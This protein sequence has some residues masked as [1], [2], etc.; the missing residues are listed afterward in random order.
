[1]T[2]MRGIFATC[3]ARAASGHAAAAPP[4]S[5]MNSRRFIIALTPNPSIH[6]LTIAGQAV[7][8]SKTGPLMSALGQKQRSLLGRGGG[9]CPLLLQYRTCPCGAVE[10]R[11]VPKPDICS[12]AN[13][14][15]FDHL[16]GAPGCQ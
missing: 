1:M 5:V 2:P 9:A 13:C 4:T 8:R 3:C 16:V 7:Q 14:S 12:A 10:R 6:G 11:F 15:L